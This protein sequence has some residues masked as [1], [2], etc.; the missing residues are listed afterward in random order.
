M[1]GTPNISIVNFIA[2]LDLS[3]NVNSIIRIISTTIVLGL[4]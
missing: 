1:V 2:N 4:G 3:V